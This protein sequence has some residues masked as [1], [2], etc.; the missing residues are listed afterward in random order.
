MTKHLNGNVFVFFV[1]NEYNTGLLYESGII[2]RSV[3]ESTEL[4]WGL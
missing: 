3:G 2:L 1:E 4:K